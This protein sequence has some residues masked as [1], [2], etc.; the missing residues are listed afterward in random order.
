MSLKFG[1]YLVE[2]RI[3]SP[4]QFCG[5][6]K[7]QQESGASLATVAIRKNIL[8]IKQ[9][10]NILDQQ[11]LNPEKSFIQIAV[12]NDYLD[13]ADAE[14]L[15][16]EQQQS[17]P[18]IRKLA[19]ECG[20]LTPRQC[21]VLYQHFQRTG[22]RPM[23]RK[24]VNTATTNETATGK[25]TEARENVGPPAPKFKQRPVIVSQYTSPAVN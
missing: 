8:T 18:S 16:V 13:K 2:Q 24:S 10:A 3:I 9:V 23:V 14:I 20:L 17:V 1:I 5:L 15:L 19:E 21:G 6:V 4:E 11:E 12:E 25:P 7:I 22:T